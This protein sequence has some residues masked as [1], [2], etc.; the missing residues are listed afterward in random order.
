MQPFHYHA[1]G[2]M[3]EAVSLLASAPEDS[4]VIAG[5]SDLLVQMR[6]GSLHR[7]HVVDVKRIPEL[8]ERTFDPGA[9]LRFGAAVSC[10]VL[11][12]DEQLR[13]HYPGL[14]DA[15][16]LIGGV[17]TQG[18]A[19]IGGNVGN[20]APSA[21][22]IPAL[23]VHRATVHVVGSKGSRTI[24]LDQFCKGPGTHVLASDEIL[25]SFHVPAPAPSSAGA[26]LRF[27]PRG[28]MDIAVAGVAVWLRLDGDQIAEALMALASVAPIPLPVPAVSEF[29]VG[30][31]P[32]QDLL[33][34]AA[35]IAS[36]A[37]RPITDHRGSS[38]QRRHLVK[39]LATR[40]M[41]TAL[42]RISGGGRSS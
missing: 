27:I 14:I 31:K 18:R 17:A 19:T 11:C 25:V 37:A 33:A 29:L 39:V 30:K 28:E 40:S 8:S 35:V 24:P 41:E 26:Y 16:S 34:E 5:G 20:A 12:E 22:S 21:D 2:T 7:S 3:V 9:G 1:P 6:R 38:E 4:K 10:A 36:N 15:F 13:R 23:I 32:T 42:R